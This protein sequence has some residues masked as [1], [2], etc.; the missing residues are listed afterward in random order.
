MKTSGDVDLLDLDRGLPTTAEDVAALHALRAP[1][2]SRTDYEAWLRSLPA[3]TYA[4]LR[5]RPVSIGEPFRL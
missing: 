2:L 4:E 1:S 3:P 5:R